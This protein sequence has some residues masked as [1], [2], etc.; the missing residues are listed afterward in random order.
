[1][2]CELGV[3]VSFFP[4][5][6]TTEEIDAPVVFASFGQINPAEKIDDFEGIEVKDKFVLT[7]S[8]QRPGKET[9]KS[10]DSSAPPRRGRRMFARGSGGSDKA[11][12]GGALGT[13]VIAAPTAPGQPSPADSMPMAV[14]GFGQ[15]SMTLGHASSRLPTLMF[16]DPI[17]D[18][19]VKATGLSATS[20][21][22]PLDGLRVHFKYS[23]KKETKED[24]NVIGLFPGTDPNK[25]KEVVIFQRAL[26]PRRRRSKG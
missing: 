3:D 7:F 20:K 25:A 10:E 17:R 23:A 2:P 15:P 6:L 12:D 13:I 4:Y 22:V 19:I 11:P 1:M 26:R 21:P 9:A 8:G 16:A 18:T 24:R 14:F 5:G